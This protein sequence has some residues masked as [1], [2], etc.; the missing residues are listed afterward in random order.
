MFKVAS[1][2]SGVQ[3]QMAETPTRVH[4]TALGADSKSRPKKDVGS[5][6]VSTSN[7]VSTPL[8][9]NANLG[10]NAT[11][12]D[13]QPLL[14]A[15]TP[16]SERS[17]FHLY[18][19]MYYHDAIC[20]GAVDMIGQ[21]TFSSGF[22]V[23][24][25]DK[26]ILKAYEEAISRLNVNS[27]LPEMSTDYLVLGMHCSSL[28]YN[29]TSRKFV[30]LMCHSA[31]SL[32]LT[33][34]PFY[35]QDPL[36]KVTFSD[37]A[38][39]AASSTAKELEYLK[40]LVGVGVL[41]KIRAGHLT[42]DPLTTIFIP[43]KTF[44]YTNI[45]TSYYKRVLPI[46]LIEKNLFRGTLVESARRQ[47]GIMQLILGEGE[48]WIPTVEDMT[49]M[50][51]LFMNADS[52]P[53]GAIVAT[54]SG[55]NV[56]E[57]RQGGEFW[58]VTDFME[59]A[60]SYKLRALGISE[61]FLSGDANYSVSDTSMTIFVEML[62]NYRD[63]M[64]RKFFYEKLFPL[65]SMTHG[66][67]QDAKGRVRVDDSLKNHNT[68][69]HAMRTLNNS[70]NLFIPKI[71]WNKQLK[72]E[73]DTAQLEILNTLSTKGVPIPLRVIA[74]AG[75]VNLDSLL[76]Q[77]DEDI[78]IRTKIAAYIEKI[79][80]FL[81]NTMESQSTALL[82]TATSSLRKSS[83][84]KRIPVIDREYPEMTG[85]S[86]TGKTKSLSKVEQQRINDRANRQ[87]LNNLRENNLRNSSEVQRT[88]QPT[89]IVL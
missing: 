81:S 74:A 15:L 61:G 32:E 10:T 6:M 60:S 65:I 53:L 33:D 24:G 31:D 30:D 46:Y 71:I 43:R 45:P 66:Y 86:K 70:T 40:D 62:R 22:S 47:R 29:E 88:A 18:R 77:Q 64:T 54:R 76:N 41:N 5:E 38:K 56:Q 50:T 59:S 68:T 26:P 51:D 16:Q 27:L 21:S 82:A 72:Q 3:A 7:Q 12:I 8:G 11:T 48:E 55:V 4:G 1:K 67:K 9:P 13:L 44:S 52:D 20:G 79:K 34:I 57:I 78:D 83:L 80:P 39:K 28:L 19:D 84:T 58:K 75:G 69:A 35:S 85:Y 42:L 89:K 49:F 73:G 17:M 23:C 2:N 14:Y 36:I 25:A 63:M 87:I 37:A